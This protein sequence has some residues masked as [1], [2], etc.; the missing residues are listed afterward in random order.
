MCVGYISSCSATLCCKREMLQWAE[1]TAL[2]PH[3][4]L[5]CISLG[6]G[7]VDNNNK[8]KKTVIPDVSYISAQVTYSFLELYASGHW[9]RQ[10]TMISPALHGTFHAALINR[11][12]TITL[13]TLA[14]SGHSWALEGRWST[15][16]WSDSSEKKSWWYHTVV[17]MLM[18]GKKLP[19]PVCLL[20]Y[21]PTTSIFHNHS[22]KS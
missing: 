2:F 15:V 16:M 11:D 5:N 20:M 7:G 14:L 19:H 22:K 17:A 21:T 13:F 10:E 12:Y 18:E 9:L 8:K 4:T 6:E 1:L 3:Q